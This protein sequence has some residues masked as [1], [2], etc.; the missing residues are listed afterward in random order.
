MIRYALHPDDIPLP[1]ARVLHLPHVR[2]Y[3]D[4]LDAHAPGVHLTADR[5]VAVGYL[6]AQAIRQGEWE[7][8]RALAAL[9]FALDD[10]DV[11][12]LASVSILDP[13][14]VPEPFATW[15]D[16][17]RTAAQTGPAD[18]N[19]EHL[20]RLTDPDYPAAELD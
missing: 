20:A 5:A 4:T 2:R 15:I 7:S 18:D 17:A 12:G 6:A 10:V 1:T 9:S 14:P 11:I 3:L 8:H 19:A 13:G 16:V